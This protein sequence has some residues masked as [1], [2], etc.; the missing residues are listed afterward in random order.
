MLPTCSFPWVLKDKERRDRW[1]EDAPGVLVHSTKLD[2]QQHS[3]E[4]ADPKIV[5][6]LHLNLTSY[7]GKMEKAMKERQ[8][9]LESRTSN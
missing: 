3:W 1:W 6:T 7:G 9:P 2:A 4:K 5:F 8:V